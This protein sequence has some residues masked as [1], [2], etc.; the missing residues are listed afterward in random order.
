MLIDPDGN[1]FR[2]YYDETN[3]SGEVVQRYV[4][5]NG[6][7]ATMDNGKKYTTGGNQF[8]DDAISSYNYIIDNDADT[9]RAMSTV[10]SDEDVIIK[11]KYIKDAKYDRYDDKNSTIEYNFEY[12]LEMDDGSI[13]SPA[14]GFFHEVVH[15][16]IDK[17]YTKRDKKDSGLRRLNMLYGKP[18][19]EEMHNINDY[20]GPA[21]DKLNKNGKNEAKRTSHYEG[22]EVPT[23]NAT[24]TE[25]K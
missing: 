3:E 23:K 6:K 21:S 19:G 25:I 12:G 22:I 20:E 7:K 10:A 14:L 5:F 15:S 2:I 13:Q 11:V 18:D 1:I 8:V 4:D 9:K 16:F 24:S 17:F